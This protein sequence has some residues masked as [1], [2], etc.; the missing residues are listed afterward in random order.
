MGV[1][2]GRVMLE[3]RFRAVSAQA[4]VADGT[5]N[6]VITIANA[7]LFKVKQEVLVNATGLPQLEL[8]VKDIPSITTMVVGPRG[9][10]IRGTIDISAYTTAA[11]GNIFANEQ[12][13]PPIDYSEIMRGV[14]EEEP[15]VAL[16]NFLVDKLG[17]G[18]DASNPLPVDAT[19]TVPPVT[20][21]LDAI[22]PP[23]R[24]DPDNVLIVGSEDGT[25]TG[26]KR[27]VKIDANG[28]T[29]VINMGGLVPKVFDDIKLT[30]ATIA[31]SPVVTV[32]EYRTGGSGGTLV[33]TL[34][35]SYDIAGNVTEVART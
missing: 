20:V 30:Y 2:T 11:G 18:Y 29:N 7:T 8:E 19:V 23:T 14:F 21:V 15:T 9:G 4:F 33:A 32:A 34:T 25:K 12:K 16:R 10:N 35:L 24:P 13:R 1:W 28:N 27:A 5:A 3:K 22:T 6:G 31:G 17:N 26:Y